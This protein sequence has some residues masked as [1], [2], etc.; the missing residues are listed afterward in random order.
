MR[1]LNVNVLAI[2]FA[3]AF[4]VLLSYDLFFR[5]KCD[6]YNDYLELV[7]VQEFREAVKKYK[8]KRADIINPTMPLSSEKDRLKDART[9]WFPVDSLKKFF[10]VSE[11]LARENQ[12]PTENM[13]VRFFY[14]VYPDNGPTRDGV[15]YRDRHTLFFV[16]TFR[17]E[18]MR[19]VDFDPVSGR[20]LA[21]LVQDSLQF[22]TT[23]VMFFNAV[24][25]NMRVTEDEALIKNQ[26]Q[27]C[28]PTCPTDLSSLL[29]DIDN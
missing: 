23:R 5:P 12:I 11:K 16:P 26:G 10:A 18:E 4:A 28:P 24:S 13:G 19:D 8:V 9:C 22:D 6:D 20:P 7:T 3:I 21:A 29:N 15:N 27:L 2:F 1:T 17:D 25:Y 14:A